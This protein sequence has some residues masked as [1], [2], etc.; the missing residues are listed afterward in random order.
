[1]D[2]IDS[3]KFDKYYKASLNQPNDKYNERG[4]NIS[5]QKRRQALVPWTSV[6]RS[7]QLKTKTIDDDHDDNN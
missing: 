3:A 6:D 2:I 4:I 1:M 7:K 5:S